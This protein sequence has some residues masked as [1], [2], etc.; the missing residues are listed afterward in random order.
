[1]TKRNGEKGVLDVDDYVGLSFQKIY[2]ILD[3]NLFQGTIKHMIL[4]A[5]EKASKGITWI[6]L[7]NELIIFE[8]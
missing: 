8:K 4:F 7:Y 6:E 2:S 1:M 3:N 5:L